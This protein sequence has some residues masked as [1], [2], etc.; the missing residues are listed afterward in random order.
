MLVGLY[1]VCLSGVTTNAKRLVVVMVCLTNC[2]LSVSSGP[3]LS[4][5]IQIGLIAYG[6]ITYSIEKQWKLLM[7]GL[8]ALYIA[9]EIYSTYPALYEISKRLA[10]NSATAQNRYLIFEY[11]SIQVGKTPWFGVGLN[12][13]ERPFWMKE[14]IDNQWMLVAVQFGLPAFIL[15]LCVFLNSLIR[16]GG[17]KFKRGSDLYNIRLGWNIVLISIMLTLA[18]VALFGEVISMT[19]FVLGAGA[20]LFYARED[21]AVTSAPVA[22]PPKRRVILGDGDFEDEDDGASQSGSST[23]AARGGPSLTG[24]RTLLR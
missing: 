15:L 17:G 7:G 18:T 19:F 22:N 6:K 12:D 5:L 23:A 1:Y 21:D 16:A 14:S 4:A 2:V 24:G 10:L 11:G 20:F 3:L 13:W 9:L 8:A